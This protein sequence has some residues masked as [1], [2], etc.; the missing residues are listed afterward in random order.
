MYCSTAGRQNFRWQS[1]RWN[2]S[3]HQS[4]GTDVESIEVSTLVMPEGGGISQVIFAKI[5]T[6]GFDALIRVC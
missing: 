1:E 4:S 5:D 6:E 3:L 2:N